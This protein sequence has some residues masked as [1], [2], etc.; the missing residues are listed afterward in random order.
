MKIV[1]AGGTG[2]LGTALAASLRRDAHV[3]TIVT[4][5]PSAPDHVPWSDVHAFDGIDA[6]INLAGESLANGRWTTSRKAA[7][8]ESRLKPTRTIVNAIRASMRRPAVLLNASAVGIY[9]TQRSEALTE[10]SPVGNDFLASVCAAWES[11]ALAAGPMTRVVLLRSGVVLDRD[12]GALP[13]LARPFRFFA[14]GPV[15][16]GRQYL[17]WI[18]VDDWVRLVG[19]AIGTTAIDGPLNATA[20]GPVTNRELAGALARALRR[21]AAMPAPAFAIR[22]VLGEMADAL[23]LNGQRVLPAK[24]AAHGFQFRYPDL[25]SALRQLYG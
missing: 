22:L 4:R 13:K 25:E 10:E 17:S 23:I 9:G 20:P 6:V 14:G 3:V 11:A 18:H 15:G 7:I 8:L 1:I 2:F 12:E 24:A 5:T 19:W 16:S 21:P